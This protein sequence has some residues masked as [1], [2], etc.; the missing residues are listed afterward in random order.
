M[1]QENIQK[2]LESIFAQIV[3]SGKFSNPQ[4]PIQKLLD[5][6]FVL[7]P[8]DLEQ[9]IIQSILEDSSP[10][11]TEADLDKI[12]LLVNQFKLAKNDN[13]GYIMSN[14]E[15]L[16]GGH[17]R[18]EENGLIQKGEF[19]RV[20]KV[21]DLHL[22]NSLLLLVREITPRST[23]ED[24]INEAKESYDKITK[25]IEKLSKHE[26]LPELKASFP[27]S[28][29][30]YVIQEY[31]KGESIQQNILSGT[32]FE[33]E[34]IVTLLKQL[35]DILKFAHELDEIHGNMDSSKVIQRYPDK[36]I[37][38][39][40]FGLTPG[41]EQLG[42]YKAP[43]QVR[44]AQP[45]SSWDLYAVGIIGIRAL[46]GKS[47]DK[48]NAE[49]LPGNWSKWVRNVDPDLIKILNKMIDSDI[50]KRYESASDILNALNELKN[51]PESSSQEAQILTQ[52]NLLQ[53]ISLWRIFLGLGLGLGLILIFSGVIKDIIAYKI[54]FPENISDKNKP[55]EV[56]DDK[57]VKG[58]EPKTSSSICT[59]VIP[60]DVNKQKEMLDR[61]KL[62][63][64]GKNDSDLSE[65][66]QQ[67]LNKLRVEI[68]PT[69]ARSNILHA[70]NLVCKVPK[71]F[72][73][74]YSLA[75][76]WITKWSEDKNNKDFVKIY[77]ENNSCPAAEE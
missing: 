10:I 47:E 54:I 9:F 57:L 14:Q 1:N 73:E 49:E 38:L 2:K 32:K 18:I 13:Q 16:I 3:N 55:S 5:N 26:S 69:I 43:E 61:L 41:R 68:A 52:T 8:D 22:P 37:S 46:I 66:C 62:E 33:V 4:K 44:N 6:I 77:L 28:G 17:Y 60:L 76:I 36:K 75:K 30:F 42:A 50:K 58:S 63:F 24:S 21:R 70:L 27:D 74:S 64:T 67:T 35:L 45:N 11:Q 19:Q 59:K 29:K 20:Y 15:T 56:K 51:S 12:P 71:K 39:R 23:S 72:D 48:I 40:D 53:Q 31:I 65:N 25:S 34:E 7:N